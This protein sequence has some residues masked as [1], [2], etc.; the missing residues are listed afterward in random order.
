MNKKIKTALAALLAACSLMN[1]TGCSKNESVPGDLILGGEV[2]K[3]HY[4]PITLTENNTINSVKLFDA[5]SNNKKNA[6]FS[7][8]SLNMALGLIGEGADGE[9]KARIDSYLRTENFADF[10]ESYIERARSLTFESEDKSNN[11][12]EIAN[13]FWADNR[14]PF[15]DEYKRC[16]S[17][18]FDA[19][20]GNLDFSDKEN[21]INKINGWV[22][23]KTHGVIPFIF[24]DYNAGTETALVNTVYFESSWLND[25][26]FDNTKKESFTLPN[27]KSKQLSLMYNDGDRYFEND[28]ATAFGCLYKNDLMFIGILPK[29][30]GEFT[31]ESL[32]IPLLLASATDEYEVSAVMPKL[33]FE[34]A[35]SL[36]DALTAAGLGSVF[37]KNNAELSGISDKPPFI[38]DILQKT[39]LG[40]NEH[41]TIAA[42]V[43]FNYFGWSEYSEP[44]DCRTVRLDRP[45]AFMI[46]DEAENQILFVGKVTEP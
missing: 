41:N 14:I 15:N 39:C 9:T 7:P 11:A 25:W 31:L 26:D 3:T 22:S 33:A 36:K 1:L 43:T 28:Q 38:S 2:T 32:D 13:A 44:K 8:L 35:F 12:L 18:K 23:E 40:L 21:T 29:K 27:G 6:M 46:Y 24:S 4:S 17:E 5:I 16:V 34:T 37:D 20:I 30:T 10:A 42:A 45:F 19:E